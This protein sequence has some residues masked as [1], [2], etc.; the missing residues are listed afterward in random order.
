MR[1]VRNSIDLKY[2]KEISS[3]TIGSLV[4]AVV[5]FERDPLAL[6]S[7]LYSDLEHI[8]IEDGSRQPDLWGINLYPE[9]PESE[10]IEFDSLIN[11]RPWQG[12]R[13]RDI[14]NPDIREKI[15]ETAAR[16]VK[17]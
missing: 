6:D 11:I 1:I 5:D 3:A 4:K 16:K 7:E 14:E 8:L 2:L 15:I 9:L 17:R 12:N 10:F 13:S